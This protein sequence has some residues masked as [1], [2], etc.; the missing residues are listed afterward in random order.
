MLRVGVEPLPLQATPLNPEGSDFRDGLSW[1]GSKTLP[2][3]MLGVLS[4]ATKNKT[5]LLKLHV[6]VQIR[7]NPTVSI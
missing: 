5:L 1:S 4:Q 7:V 6:V 3:I 2:C